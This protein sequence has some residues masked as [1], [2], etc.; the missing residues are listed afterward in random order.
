M[1]WVIAYDIRSTP[2]RSRVARRLEQ[3]GLR[4]QKSVFLVQMLPAQTVKLIEELGELID[5]D[6]DQVAAWPL[7]QESPAAHAQAGP[8]EGPQFQE[9]VI[10]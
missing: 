9:T 4:V 3:A 7:R 1:F 8:P 10:W 2:R 5:R 6:T